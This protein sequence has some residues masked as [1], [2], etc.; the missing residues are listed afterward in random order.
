MPK[1]CDDLTEN[2]KFIPFTGKVLHFK[3]V[4]VIKDIDRFYFG[5]KITY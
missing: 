1:R 4:Y 5:Q 3:S 2:V